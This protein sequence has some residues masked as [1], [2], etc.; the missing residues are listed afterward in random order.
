ML[1]QTF[2]FH[3][4]SGDIKINATT[5]FENCLKAQREGPMG[6]GG[7]QDDSEDQDLST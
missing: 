3:L 2:L 7:I 6:L 4:R 5:D 1:D